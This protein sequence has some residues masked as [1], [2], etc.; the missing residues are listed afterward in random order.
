MADS[1]KAQFL[2]KRPRIERMRYPNNSFKVDLVE[3]ICS[4]LF[5][6]RSQPVISNQGARM[7]RESTLARKRVENQILLVRGQ[8]ILLD[9]DL[10]ALYG[11]EVRS[12][13]QAIRRNRKRFPSDFVFQLTPEEDRALES[14]IV[15]SNVGR[16]GRRYL[17]YAFTE[18]GTIMAASVLNS[19]Q[20]IEM[21]IFVVRAFVRLRETLATHKALAAKLAELEQKLEKHDGAIT[22]IIDAIRALMIPPQKPLRQIGFSR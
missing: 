21:S 1:G 2:P 15:I 10:A 8:R 14:Q 18:H 11:V 12:L 16:G 17:P 9:S 6:L 20:A 5:S 19:P 13:N 22:E 7:A 4:D 3:G